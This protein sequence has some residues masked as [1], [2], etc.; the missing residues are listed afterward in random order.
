MTF[1]HKILLETSKHS[2]FFKVKQ[3]Q[4]INYKTTDKFYIMKIVAKKYKNKG[5]KY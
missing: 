3:K 2:N 1:M 5:K 4:N